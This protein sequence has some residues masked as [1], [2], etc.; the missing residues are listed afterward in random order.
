ML[1][2]KTATGH[3]AGRQSGKVGGGKEGSA[4]THS[5][6]GGAQR[7][8]N[9]DESGCVKK[10][11]GWSSGNGYQWQR[12]AGSGGGEAVAPPPPPRASP[13]RGRFAESGSS[14]SGAKQKGSHA[15]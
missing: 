7:G 11:G 10:A 9:R 15:E 4:R 6:I 14:E 13:G 1:W 8:T 2:H 12:G 3:R 5:I